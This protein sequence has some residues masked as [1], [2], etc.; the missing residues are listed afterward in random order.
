MHYAIK[1]L[2]REREMIVSA[3]K[4]GHQEKLQDLQG[5]DKALG[6]LRLLQENRVKKASRYSFDT[7]PPIEGRG[8]FSNY[9]LM[10][11]DETDDTACWDEYT[12]PDGS[13]YLLC[14]GDFIV[15]EKPSN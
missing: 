12:K 3:L 8:G 9:R 6:W 7:L 5:I 1:I 10:L 14:P 2:E 4:D 15:E 13:H 11:D